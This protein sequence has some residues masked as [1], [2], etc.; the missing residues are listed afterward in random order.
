[1]G[2]LKSYDFIKES[3]DLRVLRSWVMGQRYLVDDAVY[4]ALQGLQGLLEGGVFDY[5]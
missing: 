1:M 2:F 4:W 5:H 3:P